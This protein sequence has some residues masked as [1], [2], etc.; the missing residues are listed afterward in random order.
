MASGI[1]L[2]LGPESG[3]R[4]PIVGIISDITVVFVIIT[5]VMVIAVIMWDPYVYVA[6]GAPTAG[7]RQ[8]PPKLAIS[9]HSFSTSSCLSKA[10]K[11][12]WANF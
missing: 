6:F 3:C 7:W 2:V 4:M 8:I 12:V 10:C 1:P 11:E 5:V 9:R